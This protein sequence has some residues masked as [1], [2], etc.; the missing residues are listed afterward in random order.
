MRVKK[1]TMSSFP[2]FDKTAFLDNYGRPV[3]AIYLCKICKFSIKRNKL[4]AHLIG[5]H[6]LSFMPHSAKDYDKV[7]K[8]FVRIKNP[9]LN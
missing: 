2:Q 5:P 6:K 9:F 8:Y 1:L 3:V 7:A 4:R